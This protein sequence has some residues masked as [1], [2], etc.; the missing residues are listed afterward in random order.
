LNAIPAAMDAIDRGRRITRQNLQKTPSAASRVATRKPP[1]RPAPKKISIARLPVTGSDIF[2]RDED[3]AFLDRAWANQDINIVTIVAWAGVGKSTLI[4]HWLRRMAGEKYR[5]AELVFG[6]SFTDRALVGALHLR[7]NFLMPLFTGLEIPHD[8][9]NDDND[10]DCPTSLLAVAGAERCCSDDRSLS[11]FSRHALLFGLFRIRTATRCAEAE[12]IAERS[13][14]RHWS[15]ELHRLRGVFLAAFC[16]EDL[17]IEASFCEAIRIA[18]EQK[19]V[20]LEKRAEATY[21]EYRRKKA[22][23][24]GGRG[25]RLPL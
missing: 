22:S 13:E 11:R 25:I 15:A 9:Q 12:A 24:S 19:S 21:A 1:V 3:I 7:M 8:R 16:V 18:K 2:G 17:E 4:N 23:G 5:S 20:L 10:A 6:W 14:E